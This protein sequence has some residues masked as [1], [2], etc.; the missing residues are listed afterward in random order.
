MNLYKIVNTLDEINRSNSKT[1]TW[2]PS[3][4]IDLMPIIYII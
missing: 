2:F 1:P 4:E 3:P